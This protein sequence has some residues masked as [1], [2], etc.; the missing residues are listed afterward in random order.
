MPFMT[1]ARYHATVYYLKCVQKGLNARQIN[2]QQEVMENCTQ[3]KF[4]ERSAFPTPLSTI[5]RKRRAYFINTSRTFTLVNDG[6]QKDGKKVV[7]PS[8]YKKMLAELHDKGG[9]QSIHKLRKRVNEF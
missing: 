7:R 9:H 8:E 6:L 3:E 5:N 1:E 2:W 4:N